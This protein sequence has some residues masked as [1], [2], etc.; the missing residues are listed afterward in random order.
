[1]E[2]TLG[3]RIRDLRKDN[4]LSQA[5]LGEI[6]GLGKNAISKI[7]KGTQ[8]LLAQDLPAFAEALGTTVSYLV[9]GIKDENLAT[10]ED[11]DLTDDTIEALRA[12]KNFVH[13][14]KE[15]ENDTIVRNHFK[16][17][18]DI[19]ARNSLLVASMYEYFTTYSFASLPYIEEE[20][21]D[22]S[23]ELMKI[24]ARKILQYPSDDFE[25]VF[26]LRLQDKLKKARE[27]FK[28]GRERMHKEDEDHDELLRKQWAEASRADYE[29]LPEEPSDEEYYGDMFNK[30]LDQI[31]K[32][33]EK[34]N[35]QS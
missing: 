22:G 14:K 17:V 6:V 29:E 10:A 8:S 4:D 21:E 24:Y 31:R 32:Q 7:E 25:E 26:R 34:K 13:A 35:G 23:V 12:M 11:L 15:M 27:D 2:K 28:E 20:F 1:M 30:L 5:A 19:L 9:T 3:E 16:V 33:E 18:F